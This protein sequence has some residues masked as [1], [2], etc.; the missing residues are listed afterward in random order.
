MKRSEVIN[1]LAAELM[2]N[3]LDAGVDIPSEVA[4]EIS[5]KMLAKLELDVRMLPPKRDYIEHYAWK[6]DNKWEKE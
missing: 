5:D 4:K 6:T 2:S 3:M 1:T